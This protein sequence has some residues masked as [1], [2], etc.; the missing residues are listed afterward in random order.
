[1][2]DEYLA[3]E[4]ETL[5]PEELRSIQEEKLW[6]Q[7]A[8]VCDRSPFYQKKFAD[9]GLGPDDIRTIEDLARLPLTTKEELR[10]SQL[11]DPPLG[12]HAAVPLRDVVRIHSSTG[13]TGRPSFVGVTSHD[14]AVWTDL[15][16]RSLYTQGIRKSDVVLHAAGLTM[17]V[18]GLPVKDATEALGATFVPIGT[19]A[20]EKAVMALQALKA[21]VLHC[22]PS[23]A[24]YLAEYVR[25]RYGLDPRDLGLERIVCGA[26]PGGGIPAVRRRI[27]GE[28]N[29][30]LLEGLGNADMAPI[31]FGE[32]FEQGG[33]HFSAQEYIFP[34]VIDPYTEESLA[35]EEGTRGELVYTAIDRECVPLLRFRTRD[36]VAVTAASCTCGRTSFRLRCFGRTDDMLIV[37]GV[38]VFPSAIKDTISSLAPDTTGEMQILLDQPGPKVA[39]PLRIIAEYGHEVTDLSE[40][41]QRI[42]GLIKD[43]L[44]IPCAVDLVPPET[45]PR[46]EMKGQL[47]RKLYEQV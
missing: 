13:T 26:E 23:Y 38:N 24:I 9:A 7:V 8:Y 6:R 39:P 16:A 15:T 17:F 3:P 11:A 41:R 45:L 2:A 34:E 25:S 12:S 27:E 33:M 37:L 47:V 29:A 4:I 40:L 5:P 22:T 10:D 31:I 21:N 42:E 36:R 44:T 35:I 28:W 46:Y 30:T 18:G 20:S 14:A 1:V 43:R 19:G 32:C